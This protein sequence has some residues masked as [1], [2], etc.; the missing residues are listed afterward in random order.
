MTE[1][2]RLKN[3]GGRESRWPSWPASVQA[4]N[5][6]E[7]NKCTKETPYSHDGKGQWI[8]PDAVYQRQE[9]GWLSG[10]LEVYRCPH[11]NLTFRVELPQ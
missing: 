5:K 3:R 10:D 8:H 1:N 9:D 11:C 7:R 4:M 6:Q 2:A